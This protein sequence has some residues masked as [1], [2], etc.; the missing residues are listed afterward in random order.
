ML[1]SELTHLE[2]FVRQVI[3]FNERDVNLSVTGPAQLYEQ[4]GQCCRQIKEH[5]TREVFSAAKDHAIRRYVQFHQSGLVTLSDDLFAGL[6]NMN[7][8]S[9]AG[10]SE[11]LLKILDQVEEVSAYLEK[12]FYSYFDTRHPLSNYRCDTITREVRTAVEELAPTITAHGISSTL[13]EVFLDSM[14]DT[15]S[16]ARLNSPDREQVEHLNGLIHQITIMLQQPAIPDQVFANLLYVQNFNSTQFEGWLREQIQSELEKGIQPDF[17]PVNQEIGISGSRRPL[18]I[19]LKEWYNALGVSGAVKVKARAVKVI[20]L[21]LHISVPQLA[22]FVRLCYL[23]G[24][25]QIKNI[26]TIMRFFTEHFE[27]KKQLQISLKSFGKAFYSADQ[28][29]AAAVRD[30]LQRMIGLIDKNY[31]PKT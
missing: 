28:S 21:P 13:K 23:E 20:H 18:D 25:F 14:D 30:Y 26:S 29:T 10:K 15:L 6:R 5:L 22:L 9:V 3:N 31:F 1:R 8:R 11:L 16:R 2:T 19:L 12:Q 17:P 24:C 7:E 27:T 4:V